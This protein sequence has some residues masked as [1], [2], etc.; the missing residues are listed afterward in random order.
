M[1][2]ISH[3]GQWVIKF[4]DSVQ[5]ILETVQRTICDGPGFWQNPSK[6]YSG[7]ASFHSTTIDCSDLISELII[8]L[9]IAFMAWLT[10]PSDSFH[11]AF[12]SS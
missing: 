2:S 4:W 3:R 6:W 8:E 5:L 12:W 10:D 11:I 1:A 7:I 9:A